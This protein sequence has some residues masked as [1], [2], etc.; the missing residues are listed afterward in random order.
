MATVDHHLVD[1]RTKS[2]SESIEEDHVKKAHGVIVVKIL[3]IASGISNP[4][5]H[6]TGSD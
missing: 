1:V 4:I 2:D 6:L 5:K 3:R